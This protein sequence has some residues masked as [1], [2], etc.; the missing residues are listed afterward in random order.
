MS[1]SIGPEPYKFK[2][3]EPLRQTSREDRERLIAEAGYNVFNLR[4]EDVYIDLLTDSGTS[5]MSQFQW[6][7]LL[8]GDES[9]AGSRSFFR[10]QETVTNIT[11]YPYVLPTHQG[12][13]AENILAAMLIQPGSV[14]PGNMH[15][16]TTRAHI[17]LKGATPLDLVIAPGLD[18]EDCHPFKANIDLGRLEGVLQEHGSRK[19]PFVLITVTCNNNGGQPA[20]MENVRSAAEICRRYRVPLFFDAARFAENCYFIRT[21]ESG[22]QD[23]E[24]LRIAQEMFSYGDGCVMSSKKDGLV[25]IGG[26]MAFSDE[27][28]YRQACGLAV[29]YE[30]FPTYGGMAGRDMEALSVG[31]QE[32]L[33][34]PYLRFR[35]EQVAHLAGR[36][37][38]G[39]VPIVLPPG[40]HAVYLDARRF[41]PH[42]PQRE[43]RGQAL[44]VALYVEAGI[45]G[46][47][48]GPSMFGEEDTA[49]GHEK[50]PDLELVRL[51]IPRR[52]YTNAHMDFVADSILEIYHN[53]VN[54]RGLKMVYQTPILRHFTC[55]FD[56]A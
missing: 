19:V 33:E 26:F 21:R 46:V 48:L 56:Y 22:Y 11:G 5:T 51:A 17:K 3:V 10:F 53:R 16:D 18:P 34:L 6:A 9:Y 44:V 14:I 32:V 40:G 31:L 23:R 41:A 12:R 39:G 13:G 42:I 47:D 38:E 20:S 54:L 45:R 36:L 25:N 8:L 2:M 50:Y 49:T 43:F 55:R 27:T 4:A 28:L 7:A 29:I 52:A 1:D 37:Q 15:F 24:I 35:I 30:G